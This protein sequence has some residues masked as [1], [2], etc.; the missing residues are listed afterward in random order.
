MMLCCSRAAV[1]VREVGF[2]KANRNDSVA[3]N[4]KSNGHKKGAIVSSPHFYKKVKEKIQSNQLTIHN[5]PLS[6]T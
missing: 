6:I 1:G 4:A 2:A 3:C 5:Y